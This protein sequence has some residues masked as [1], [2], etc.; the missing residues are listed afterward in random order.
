[1]PARIAY[2]LAI[3]VGA[4]FAQHVWAEEPRGIVEGDRALLDVLNT[5]QAVGEASFPHGALTAEVHTTNVGGVLDETIDVVAN[6]VWSESSTYWKYKQT[7]LLTGREPEVTEGEMIE[8]GDLHFHYWPDRK[9]AMTY[10]EGLGG[11][12]PELRLR[13][14]QLWFGVRGGSRRWSE[15]FEVGTPEHPPKVPFD[16]LAVSSDGDK[17]AVRRVLNGA[18]LYITASQKFGGNIVEYENPTTA[19]DPMWYRGTCEW[20]KLPD[21]RYRLKHCE[22]AMAAKGDKSHPNRTYE[23]TVTDFDPE[24]EI[25]ADRFRFES[26]K[27]P[28]GTQIQE[29]SKAGRKRYRQGEKAP[30]TYRP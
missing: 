20:K 19:D 21:K 8:T 25:A 28:L 26:L 24:P 1:M 5:A 9:L 6:I 12:R 29:V 22:H 2:L 4:V 18:E 13:P 14:D 16:K 27:V 23:L 11:Y 15:L 10:S 7:V 17:I 3:I 30:A